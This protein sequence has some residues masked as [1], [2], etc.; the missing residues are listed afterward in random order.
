MAAC[1][2]TLKVVVGM[3][4]M[5]EW[6]LAYPTPLAELLSAVAE[7]LSAVAE[8]LSAVAELLSA[9]CEQCYNRLQLGMHARGDERSADGQLHST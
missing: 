8:L 2:W 7:L 9:V 3:R 5:M 6:N 4:L 1:E